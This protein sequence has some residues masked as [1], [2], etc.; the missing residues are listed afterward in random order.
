MQKGLKREKL[1]EENALVRRQERILSQHSFQ[2]IYLGLP[3]TLW[4]LWSSWA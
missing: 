4:S 3:E 1:L 2:S